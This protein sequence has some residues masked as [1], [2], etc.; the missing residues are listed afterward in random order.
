MWCIVQDAHVKLGHGRDVLQTL[1][2]ILAEFYIP[3]ARKLILQIKKTCPGCLKISKKRFSAAEAD[4]PEVLKT[5]QPL[6]CYCQADI[7]GPIL[8]HNSASPTKRWVLVVLFLSS[9]AIHLELLHNYSALSITMGFRRTFALRG[10]FPI[11]WIDKGLNITRA[12][13]DLIQYELKVVSALNIKFSAI[14]LKVT[15][16]STKSK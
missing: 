13:K 6:F 16:G 14:E 15:P 2:T 10:T 1:S 4:M 5:I 11:I 9:Q 12:D 3:G 8:A 7:F